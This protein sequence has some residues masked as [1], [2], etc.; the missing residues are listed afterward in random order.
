MK[1]HSITEQFLRNPI[2]FHGKRVLVAGDIA[3]DRTFFCDLAPAGLHAV[4]A[5]ET[6]VD[7]RPGGD[8]FGSVGA[9]CNAC[10]L[11]GALGAES[12]L[13][14]VTGDDPE[15]DRVGEIF[16]ASGVRARQIRLPGVQ[17]VTRLRFY[18]HDPAADR[19]DLR[20][21][22]DKDPDASASHARA[23]KEICTRDFLDWWEQQAHASN[24]I[25]FS[26][27]GKGFLSRRVMVALNERIARVAERRA[28]DGMEPIRV[29]V[30]PKREWEKF[31]GLKVDLFKPNDVEAA[32]AVHL[33]RM[34]WSV[35]ANLR[36]LAESI[37]QKWGNDFPNIVITLGERGAAL[38]TVREGRGTVVRFPTPGAHKLAGGIAMHCGDMFAAALALSLCIDEDPASAIFFA[39][40]VAS[41]QVGKPIGQKIVGPDLKDPRNLNRLRDDAL[42]AEL[43]GEIRAPSGIRP[44]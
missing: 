24:V 42:Q 16:A 44:K 17:T 8:D 43:V 31:E 12:F 10:V 37:G 36:T 22:V 2:L 35:G 19:F 34:D 14:T 23:E 20:L 15:A 28:S 5:G 27:T 33:P 25:L 21:R 4:H 26:D 13:V 18:V 3:L 9:A 38:V 39:N 7:V 32:G 6:I 40:Y 29:V 11:A 41:V 30:D 1:T